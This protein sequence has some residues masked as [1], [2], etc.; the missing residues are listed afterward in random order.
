M[1]GAAGGVGLAGAGPGRERRV[2]AMEA[3]KSGSL[4]RLVAVAA[5]GGGASREGEGARGKDASR[6]EIRSRSCWM[7]GLGVDAVGGGDR[8]EFSI[9]DIVVGQQL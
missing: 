8:G 6:A 7:S 3:R 1:A 9:E 2:L 4:A 5:G